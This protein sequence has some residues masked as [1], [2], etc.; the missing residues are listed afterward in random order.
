MRYRNVSSSARVWPHLTNA[1]T[2]RTLDLA[3]G[4][5]AEVDVPE[6][7][8]DGFL[9]PVPAPVEPVLPAVVVET[10]SCDPEPATQEPTPKRRVKE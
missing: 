5:D 7:F 4:A 3:P 8:S 1:E 10:P 9:E 6:G 2:G